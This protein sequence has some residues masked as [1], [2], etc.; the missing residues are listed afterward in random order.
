[1]ARHPTSTELEFGL[2]LP[3][4]RRIGIDD[5]KYALARGFEDFLKLPS[6]AIFLVIIY[7][8]AG[9]LLL[10]LSW[11]YDL[12]PLVFP[13]VSGFAILGP[14]AAIGLYEISRRRELGQEVSW[15][16]ANIL[17]S[18]SMLGVATLGA[19]LLG[20]FLLWIGTAYAIYQAIFGPTPPQSVTAF[21]TQILTT[22]EGGQ[23]I[24]IGCAV[25]FLFAA[26]A[27]T[28]SVVSFPLLVDRGDVGAWTAILVSVKAVL[29]NPQIMALWGL[30]IVAALIIGSLPL[31]MGLAVV[32]PVLGHASWH[33]YRRLV[34]W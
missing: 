30:I 12:L 5:L 22:P 10:R 32:L 23:L 27:F 28:I 9:L 15:R 14:V 18:H 6:F 17:R 29:V 1:M 20:L 26:L 31:L 2:D 4:V 24:V 19:I 13:L 34:R 7:P 11:G 21:L 16:A 8:L 25:G 3:D 33:L